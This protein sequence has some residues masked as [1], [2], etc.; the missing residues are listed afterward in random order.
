MALRYYKNKETGETKRSL[1]ELESPWEEVLVAPN[2][3]FM[4]SADP[5]RGKSKIKGSEKMLKERARNH[6]RNVDLDNNI[7]VNSVNG[8]NE[9]VARSFLNTKGERR[10][11]IDDI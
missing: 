7:H 8:L 10:R 1:K 6:S 5:S 4:E 2:Q 3:K 9:N 11:K